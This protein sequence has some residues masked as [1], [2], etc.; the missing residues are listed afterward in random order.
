MKN[1]LKIISFLIT[2]FFVVSA[3]TQTGKKTKVAVVAEE[4]KH[5][6]KKYPQLKKK[7]IY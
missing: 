2:I 3:C 7:I 1:N 6:E 5:N 4:N